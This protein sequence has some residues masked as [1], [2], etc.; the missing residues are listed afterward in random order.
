MPIMRQI[1]AK[2]RIFKYGD[3]LLELNRTKRDIKKER[4]KNPKYAT[5]L[6]QKTISKGQLGQV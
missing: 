6:T 3:I 1:A 5:A 2:D 4:I